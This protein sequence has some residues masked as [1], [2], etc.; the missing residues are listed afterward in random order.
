MHATPEQFAASVE[1]GGFTYRGLADEVSTILR[2]ERR[3]TPMACSHTTISNLANGN[4]KRIHPRRAAA[5]ERAL[6]LP[7]GQLFRVEVFD[8]SPKQSTPAA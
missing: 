4:A 8:V 3:K 1:L 7:P 5:I 6:K 2:K